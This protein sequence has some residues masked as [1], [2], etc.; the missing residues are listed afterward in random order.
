ML[1]D[2]TVGPLDVEHALALTIE[3]NRQRG[4]RAFLQNGH[5]E[6][7]PFEGQRRRKCNPALSVIAAASHLSFIRA[8]SEEHT[9]ELQSPCNLVCR[10]L[11]ET[12][13]LSK[14]RCKSARR[15]RRD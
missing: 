13:K 10:L 14:R 9:S 6:W 3:N 8:R 7:T 12:K 11:L 5:G 4:F 2:G 1:L 15:N